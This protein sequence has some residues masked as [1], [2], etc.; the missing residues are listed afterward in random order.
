[1][2]CFFADQYS[3][4]LGPMI[5]SQIH[6]FDDVVRQVIGNVQSLHVLVHVHLTVDLELYYT[7]DLIQLWTKSRI[8]MWIMHS[9]WKYR[10]TASLTT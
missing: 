3:M 9:M 1:M 2:A 10:D 5:R 8:V 6:R 7:H 4:V